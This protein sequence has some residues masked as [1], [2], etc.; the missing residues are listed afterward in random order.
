MIVII[1]HII[2]CLGLRQCINGFSLRDIYRFNEN[3]N[4]GV[5]NKYKINNQPNTNN[6]SKVKPNFVSDIDAC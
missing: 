2:T 6:S 3:I 1:Q 4:K 5:N